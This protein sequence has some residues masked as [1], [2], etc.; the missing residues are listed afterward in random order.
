[1]LIDLD[2]AT[3]AQA[4]FHMGQTLVPRPI[5]WV[6]S[7]NENHSYNLAPFS[8]FSAICSDPPILMFSIGRRPDGTAKDTLVNIRERE[9]FVVQIAHSGQ[10]DALNASAAGLAPGASEVTELELATRALGDFGLPRLSGARIAYACE[11]YRIDQIGN[12]AQ[13]L[14][15]GRIRTVY[16]DD[17]IVEETANGRLKVDNRKL[18]PLARL[19]ANEYLS[20]GQVVTLRRPD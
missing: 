7:E 20:K 5:A 16:L 6:L 17:E 13:S 18:D 1:M 15:F 9:H 3:P 8:Y 19:G 14:V 10:L 11:R 12:Q 2:K 4:Y